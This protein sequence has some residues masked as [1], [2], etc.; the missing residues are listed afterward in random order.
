MAIAPNSKLITHAGI[1]RQ[2]AR[3]QKI[4]NPLLEPQRESSLRFRTAHPSRKCAGSAKFS[5]AD[6]SDG[7]EEEWRV[8]VLE[9]EP[10]PFQ[11]LGALHSSSRGKDLY[12]AADC[13]A[14]GH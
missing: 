8:R 12:I 5:K 1:L 7:K 3:R 2:R 9:G 11:L 13:H 10:V 14:L 6:A 4:S